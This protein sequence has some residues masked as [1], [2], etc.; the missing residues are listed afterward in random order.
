MY[1]GYGMLL[2][3]S[4]TAIHHLILSTGSLETALM[5]HGVRECLVGMG[6]GARGNKNH[7]VDTDN[8]AAEKGLVS[9]GAYQQMPRSTSTKS[10]PLLYSALP[11]V[12]NKVGV[13]VRAQ[14]PS[15]FKIRDTADVLSQLECLCTGRK[16]PQEKTGDAGSAIGYEHVHEV[17]KTI[18]GMASAME[19]ALCATS[20]LLRYLELYDNESEYGGYRLKQGEP[21]HIVDNA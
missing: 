4:L 5:Q 1:L 10:S 15:I 16:E 8:S 3:T 13:L 19:I 7:H 11:E 18:E 9:T 6:W 14:H 2:T 20:A 12:F 21:L 17:K